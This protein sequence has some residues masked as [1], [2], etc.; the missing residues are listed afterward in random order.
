MFPLFEKQHKKV[1]GYEFLVLLSTRK[2]KLNWTGKK[3]IIFKDAQMHI[4]M[5]QSSQEN[6]KQNMG[7]Q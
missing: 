2:K 1:K 6:T 3:K 4:M 5:L 7:L